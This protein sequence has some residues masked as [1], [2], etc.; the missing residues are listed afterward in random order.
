MSG[1]GRD[2]RDAGVHGDH[3][4]AEAKGSAMGRILM[5]DIDGT[6]AGCREGIE[7]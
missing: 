3:P 1:A 7:A 2:A 5:A 6:V 4:H